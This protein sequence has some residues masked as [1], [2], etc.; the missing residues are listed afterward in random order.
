ML[1]KSHDLKQGIGCD[2][3]T[4]EE[5]KA[6]VKY[7]I[8]QNKY[9]SELLLHW[10]G[11]SILGTKNPK[12]LIA[13]HIKPF[14]ESK[15]SEKYDVNNGLLLTPIYYKLFRLF[16]ITFDKNGKIKIS[17]KLKTERKKLS[18]SGG[19]NLRMDKLTVGTKIYL[20]F[21]NQ[22]FEDIQ[23]RKDS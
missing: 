11:C 9:K 8:Q 16:L 5:K 2:I 23:K 14:L 21:H 7:R 4:N 20:K 12:L 18:I 13:S 3:I 10:E 22:R 17:E 6:L 15:E 19:E 1:Y